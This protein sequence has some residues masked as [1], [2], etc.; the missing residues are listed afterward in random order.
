M[1]EQPT[2]L[3][4]SRCWSCRRC[5]HCRRS[6]LRFRRDI[7][8]GL[9]GEFRNAVTLKRR[10][11]RG[12]GHGLRNFCRYAARALLVH[13]CQFAVTSRLV[14][15]VGIV[16]NTLQVSAA[17]GCFGEPPGARMQG[18]EALVESLILRCQG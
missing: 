17:N 15:M 7:K 1:E 18:G 8:F 13:L 3:G 12:Y 11:F 16:I 2:S 5:G 6:N 10:G 4:R 9:N 14:R